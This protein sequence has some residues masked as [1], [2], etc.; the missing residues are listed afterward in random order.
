MHFQNLDD[1]RT[2]RAVNKLTVFF[3]LQF[4]HLPVLFL[5]GWTLTWQSLPWQTQVDSLLRSS[6][7][8]FCKTCQ[9]CIAI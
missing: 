7:A 6:R 5:E 2:N 1:T 3:P 8:V 4:P 9:C